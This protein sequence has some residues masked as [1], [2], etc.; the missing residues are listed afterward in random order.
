MAFFSNTPCIL[1]PA[2]HKVGFWVNRKKAEGN[3]VSLLDNLTSSKVFACM[4]F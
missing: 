2:A 1:S 4:Y 3:G